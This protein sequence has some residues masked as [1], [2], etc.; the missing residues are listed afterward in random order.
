MHLAGIAA[1]KLA[2]NSGDRF[3]EAAQTHAELE[4]MSLE[5]QEDIFKRSARWAGL[6]HD[7]GHAPFSH[8]LEDACRFSRRTG[9][10]TWLY[11]KCTM[12]IVE[13]RYAH[14]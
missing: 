13:G 1:E 3:R 14:E 4:G 5:E 6:L 9:N 7:I 2:A 12:P 8:T 10:L 11:F